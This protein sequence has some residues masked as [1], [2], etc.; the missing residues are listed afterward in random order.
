[1]MVQNELTQSYSDLLTKIMQCI[2]N[3]ALESDSNFR[4]GSK[5][6]LRNEI[7]LGFL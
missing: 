4:I 3:H 1:M 6:P 5:H 7:I 2:V